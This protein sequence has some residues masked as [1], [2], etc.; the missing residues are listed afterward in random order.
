MQGLK[1]D[2]NSICP[3]LC[4]SIHLS[5]QYNSL[6]TNQNRS[7][8]GVDIEGEASKEKIQFCAAILQ[9]VCRKIKVGFIINGRGGWQAG[10]LAGRHLVLFLE[11]LVPSGIPIYNCRF[12]GNLIPI[13]LSSPR[14][15]A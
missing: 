2:Q 5:V 6:K 14:S 10:R 13:L 11:M 1:W 8:V 12:H 3:S 9:N 15:L 4:I 7:K